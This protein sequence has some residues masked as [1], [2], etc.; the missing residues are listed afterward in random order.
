MPSSISV[1]ECV[2]VLDVVEVLLLWVKR[3]REERVERVLGAE[4]FMSLDVSF[5]MREVRIVGDRYPWE[6]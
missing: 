1:T 6:S 5:D 2:L 3:E 4:E